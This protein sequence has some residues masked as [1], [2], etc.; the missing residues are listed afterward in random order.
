M[1]RALWTMTS[2]PL[3]WRMK[4]RIGLLTLA[5]FAALC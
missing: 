2:Q 5:S 4:L 1:F 3:F